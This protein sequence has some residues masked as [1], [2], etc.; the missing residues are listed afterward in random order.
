[1]EFLILFL[2]VTALVCFLLPRDTEAWNVWLLLASLL[3]YAWGEPYFVVVMALSILFN[4]GMARLMDGQQKPK[5]K[6]LFLALAV[7]GNIGV[8]FVF[9]YLNFVTSLFPGGIQTHIALP[10][11]ISFFTFQ[12]MSYV[13]DVYRGA[14]VQRSL[15]DF[16]LYVSFFPQLIAGPIV[17]YTTVMAE[18]KKR[19]MDW[20]GVSRGLCRFMRGFNKKVLLSNVFSVTAEYA[21]GTEGIGAGMAWLGAL[22]YALQIFFDFSG[23][24]DMAIGLG[25]VFG[26]HFAENFDYPY[27]SGSVT[28]FWRRWHM[29]L[30]SWFRDYVYFP[31]GGSRVEGKGRLIR[32]LLIVW[33]L[34]GIWHGANWTF[35]LWG[36]LYGALIIFEKLTG[37]PKRLKKAAPPWRGL[38]RGVTLLAVLLGWVLF[39]ARDLPHAGEYLNRMF[40]A[41]TLFD[42]AFFRYL[43]EYRVFWIAGLLLSTPLFKKLKEKLAAG[44]ESGY[45]ACAAGLW[46]FFLFLCSVSCLV[47]NAHNPFIYFNF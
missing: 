21:F 33:C 45:L 11:G 3:F 26:F 12:A 2:P 13:I 23:Y 40:A 37:L 36:L 8:L 42:G 44:K 22:A 34:T 18:I 43:T 19:R 39:N 41:K 17:R 16:G 6:R 7:T 5:R 15:A 46:Q 27:I 29:S 25:E 32:N 30:G 4:Y 28:E 38:Y 9:K 10:I 47:M 31:L 1:M 14:P 35:I 24:S 20:Q